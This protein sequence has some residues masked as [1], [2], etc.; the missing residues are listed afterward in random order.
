MNIPRIIP[1]LLFKGDGLVKGVKFNNY[2]YIGDP[3]NAVKIF[4]DKEVNELFILDI[5]ATIENRSPQFNLIQQIA[6][7][8][9]MSFVVGIRNRV[10]NKKLNDSHIEKAV[11]IIKNCAGKKVAVNTSFIINLPGDTHDSQFKMLKLMGKLSRQINITFSGP[12]AF[13]PYP[14][15]ELS[16]KTVKLEKGNLD[17][18][19]SDSYLGSQSENSNPVYFYTHIARVFLTSVFSFMN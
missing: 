4:N 18:Y 15:S 8:C 10:L 2:K 6:D 17:F 1:Y 12:Q 9:Y 3:L 13:R 14:G 5:T 7:E 19:L 11:K 16:E